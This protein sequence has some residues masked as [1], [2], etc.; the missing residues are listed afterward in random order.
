MMDDYLKGFDCEEA[1]L[2]RIPVDAFKLLEKFTRK[3]DK[4][5]KTGS[6]AER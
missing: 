3:R 5:E 1:A 2:F 6:Y 4:R